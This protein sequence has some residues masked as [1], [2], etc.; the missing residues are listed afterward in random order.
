MGRFII[1]SDL[2]DANESSLADTRS[3]SMTYSTVSVSSETVVLSVMKT[4][5][6]SSSFHLE[7][8]SHLLCVLSVARNWK[9]KLLFSVS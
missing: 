8:D 4:I 3:D 6:L 2:V 9:T 5:C 7:K 1:K